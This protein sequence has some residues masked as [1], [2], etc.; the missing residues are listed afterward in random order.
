MKIILK[1]SKTSVKKY[2]ALY[3]TKNDKKFTQLRLK[4]NN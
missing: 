2:Y 1:L 3:K 4:S